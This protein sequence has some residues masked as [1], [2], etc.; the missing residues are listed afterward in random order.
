[1]KDG[2]RP[3]MQSYNLSFS[4]LQVNTTI[5]GGNFTIASYDKLREFKEIEYFRLEITR[6][7]YPVVDLEN[8]TY[9]IYQI[10]KHR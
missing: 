10:R 3:V 1:M 2:S 9:K 6:T 7:K 5:G 8:V 4:G